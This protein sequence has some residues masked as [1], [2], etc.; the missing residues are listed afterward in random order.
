M[1]APLRTSLGWLLRVP[2]T[3]SAMAPEAVAW[4]LPWPFPSLLPRPAPA[5]VGTH[6]SSPHSP[7]PPSRRESTFLSLTFET[8]ASPAWPS[9]HPS[10]SPSSHA[11]LLPGPQLQRLLHL[12]AVLGLATPPAVPFPTLPRRALTHLR[13][14][15]H[16]WPAPPRAE[17]FSHLPLIMK[18]LP[19]CSA[20]VL[21]PV[22]W[23]VI[24]SP[25]VSVLFFGL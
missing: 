21:G 25:S 17:R 3:T 9:I 1:Q 20:G 7:A 6:F 22:T 2:S 23:T 8:L 4:S 16:K 24:F 15:T 11:S 14:P 18:A 12:Q 10:G 19:V 13:S 5:T